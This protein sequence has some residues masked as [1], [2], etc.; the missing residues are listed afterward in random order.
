MMKHYHCVL[1]NLLILYGFLSLGSI[2]AFS[3]NNQAGSYLHQV[4]NYAAVYRGEIEYFY[5]PYIYKNQPYYISG[6]F[7]TGDLFYDNKYY[8]NQRMRLDTYRGQ[9]LL[10]TPR[11]Q[12][13]ILDFRK[14]EKAKIHDKEIISHYPPEGSGLK[15]GY[16][17]S[18]YQ[19]ENVALL[20]REKHDVRVLPT[21]I[22]YIFDRSM[23]YYIFHK[24]KYHSVK[25]RKSFTRLFPEFK[26]QI[27]QYS[28]KE[29]L[30]FQEQ[31]E[32]GLTLLSEYCDQLINSKTDLK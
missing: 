20:G 4:E 22:E 7:V 26:K 13:I 19:G 31:R 14:F 11:N 24:E 15:A 12:S 6:D 16:Y 32:Y 2:N 17:I 21:Q 25:N 23:N 5:N 30:D 1:F 18:F 29:R 8:P 9:M 27:K 10:L 3:Q 28:K